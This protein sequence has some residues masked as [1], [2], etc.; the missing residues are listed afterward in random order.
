MRTERIPGLAIVKG[1]VF[2]VR[3]VFRPKV[4]VQYPEV[5]NDI[6]PRHRGRLVLLYD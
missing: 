6:S 4:T 3:Q 5:V 2:A 1:M